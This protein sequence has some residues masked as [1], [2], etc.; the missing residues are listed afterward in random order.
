MPKTLD[1][2]IKDISD[3]TLGT[4]STREAAIFERAS[5]RAEI[6]VM[7]NLIDYDPKNTTETWRTIMR[8][9]LAGKV[10]AYY[11]KYSN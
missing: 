5:E 9:M 2:R 1:E 7:Y 10:D 8:N 11:K 6:I 4:L 3:D